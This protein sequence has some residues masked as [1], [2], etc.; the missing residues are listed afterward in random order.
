MAARGDRVMLTDE[1]VRIIRDAHA[2][3]LTQDDAAW[4]AGVPRRLLQTR[5]ADQLADVHWG[6][7]R[8]PKR[9]GDCD[10]SEDEIEAL[11][12]A[13]RARNGHSLPPPDFTGTGG[14]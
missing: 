1:Q 14:K 9:R 7:G 2:R 4:L 8:G 12:L 10:P 5:L 6:Q 11:K 3:G 13:I